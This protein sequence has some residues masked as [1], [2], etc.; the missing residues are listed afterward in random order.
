MSGM[1]GG[2]GGSAGGGGPVSGTLQPGSGVYNN[3]QP[4]GM[5][6][7]SP[8]MGGKP[9]MSA[10]LP[11]YFSGGG[12]G[13]Q[14]VPPGH[15]AA[16]LANAPDLSGFSAPS[17]GRMSTPP[18]SPWSSINGVQRQQ[19][20]QAQASYAN[21]ANF[22]GGGGRGNQAVPPGH[23]QAALDRAP[24]LSRFQ[25]PSMGR[26]MNPGTSQ[27]INWE[28]IMARFRPGQSSGGGGGQ[29]NPWQGGLAAMRD[30]FTNPNAQ[31][32][33]NPG[34]MAA[35]QGAQTSS[36]ITAPGDSTGSTASPTNANPRSGPQQGRP[37]GRG[38]GYAQ[39]LIQALRNRQGR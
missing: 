16:A 20:D 37:T 38:A 10:S 17:M 19:Q 18:S 28:D 11:S 22:F 27:Q 39:Q 26:V 13:N 33:T 5:G 30:R 25:A 7:P 34:S 9:P 35:S 32:V 4:I 12:R 8:T 21:Y 14:A 31:A 24:D 29:S 6:R 3:P 36:G 1:G 2:A 15:S 23:S